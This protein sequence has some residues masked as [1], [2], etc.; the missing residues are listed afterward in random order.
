[1]EI[2][3]L[4]ADVLVKRKIW[5]VRKLKRD[6]QENLTRT[7]NISPT[8]AMLLV[9]RGY[10]DCQKAREFLEPRLDA[11][12]SPFQLTNMDQVVEKIRTA[13][14]DQKKIVIYGDYDV[15]G[16]TST[17]LLTEVFS[18]LGVT[19]EYYIPDRVEEGY[20]LNSEALE[21]LAQR[22]A[23]LII[24]V[25]CGISSKNEVA[26]GQK[27]GL[28]FII[29]DHHQPPGDLPNCLI[30]NPQLEKR[31]FPWKNLAGVGVAFK[32]AQGLL[33]RF[34]GENSPKAWLKYLDLAALGTIADIVPLIGENRIIVKHGLAQIA[35]GKRIGIKALAKNANLALENITSSNVG[36]ILAPRLNACGR[37][38]D[39]G[40]G[41]KLLLATCEKEA[42]SIAQQLSLENQNRQ[43]IEGKITREALG[44]LEKMDL[45]NNKVLVLTGQDWHQGVIG[46]VASRLVE[47]FYRPVIIL[48]KQNGIYKGSGR[49]IPSFHLHRALTACQDLLE[50]FGGHSQAAGVSLKEENIQP[51]INKMNNIAKEVLTEEDLLPTLDLDGEINLEEVDFTLLEEMA[52]LEPFGCAN[53]EPLLVYRRGEIEDYKEVGNNGG[54]LKLKV[55]AGKSLWDA[56]GFNMAGYLELA[57]SREPLDLAFS[58]DKNCWNG[59]TTLQLVL[60]DV[61]SY[62]QYDNPQAQPDFLEGLFLEGGKYLEKDSYENLGSNTF[63]EKQVPR[64]QRLAKDNLLLIDVRGCND[65]IVY[66]KKL[67]KTGQK[68][69]VYVHSGKI[70]LELA[71]NLRRDLP[72]YKEK[73]G[74]YHAGLRLADRQGIEDLFLRGELRLIVCTSTFIA[75]RQI[76]DIENVIFY[77]LCFSKE[78]YSQLAIRAGLNGKQAKIHLLYGNK[79]RELNRLILAGISPERNQLAKFYLLLKK[80]AEKNN[81]L[82]FTD[83][84]LAEWANI[85]KIFGVQAESIEIWL[86]IFAELGIIE[87]GILGNNRS[88]NVKLSPKKVNLEDSAKYLEGII[89]RNK[90]LEYEDWA[91]RKDGKL[92]LELD[93]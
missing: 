74:Y 63:L 81:P 89:K 79:D 76:P 50:S 33:E 36:Y 56:I 68:S 23:Q 73:I 32:L 10:D 18:D 20:G 27:L 69:I 15:D 64:M 1:V 16:I 12:V 34:S 84:Q 83:E 8:L 51:F 48:T 24:T 59:K 25:D 3:V 7:L 13:V 85:Y 4:E 54:H 46:I 71:A 11:L 6:I 17:A 41:V 22:G 86:G 77:H 75:G 40:L 91:F 66:I 35:G 28:E 80:L 60:K 49:S 31:D 61:K 62:S 5:N 90:F 19:V 72:L 26:A 2:F 87:L 88:I 78:E 38:G 52:K 53:P 30:I 44:M 39:A 82:V 70:A 58:L 14:R 21:T 45:K 57:A 42:G 67:I 93:E 47:R 29:T 65:K 92:L 37:I 55:K 9:N 43:D